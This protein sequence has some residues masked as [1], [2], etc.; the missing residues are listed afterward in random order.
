[1]LT[2]QKFGGSSLA[3][4]ERLRRAAR[5]AARARREGALIVVVSAMGDS[6][7]DLLALARTLSPEPP[8]REL[9][10]LLST[11]ERCSAALLAITL[12][13]IGCPAR[14][15]SGPQAG[16]CA[17]GEHGDGRIVLLTPRRLLETLEEGRVAVV[18]GFQGRNAEGD[19]IT[20][21]RGGSDTSAVTLAAALGAGR[22]EIYSDVEGVYTADPRLLPEAR[23]QPL[24]DTEDMLRLAEAGAQVLH[25]RAARAA[26][27][28]GLEL[29][30]RSSFTD[31][32]GTVVRRLP[33]ALRPPYAGVTRRSGG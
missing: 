12:E 14:S 17:E 2:V 6:T 18:C 16:I 7:D 32:G 20:L 19:V 9:D 24:I 4:A 13:S 8:P 27:E 25:P 26:L 21:G 30:L 31:G 15:L 29:T 5:L 1:M 23:F 11:G 22:C 10:A 28:G 33:E 3:D